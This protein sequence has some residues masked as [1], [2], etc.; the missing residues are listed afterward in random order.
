[1]SRSR[2]ARAPKATARQPQPP[3]FFD[4]PTLVRKSPLRLTELYSRLMLISSVVAPDH[5]HCRPK[6]SPEQQIE[7]LRPQYD[8]TKLLCRSAADLMSG[9]TWNPFSGDLRGDAVEMKI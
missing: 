5:E 2:R 8:R 6:Q 1:M 7:P 4:P 3:L 9:L